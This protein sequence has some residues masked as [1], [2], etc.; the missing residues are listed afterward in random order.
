LE[1]L[2][3]SPNF[4]THQLAYHGG[5]SANIESATAEKEE[6]PGLLKSACA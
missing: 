1:K 2:S 4:L 3:V 5:K 6:L